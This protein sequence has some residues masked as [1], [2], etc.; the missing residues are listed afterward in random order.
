VSPDQ[1]ITSRRNPRIVAAA[2]LHDA[3]TRKDRGLTLLEGSRLVAE[4]VAAGVRFEVVFV[5]EGTELSGTS[6]GDR[7]YEVVPVTQPV[8]ERLAGT[9]SPTG[10]IAVM[11]I[12]SS[13]ALEPR[14]TVVLCRIADPGTAGT[15]IRSAAAFGYQVAVTPGTVDVWSPK[16]LRAAAGGHFH[17]SVLPVELPLQPTLERAGLEGVALVAAGGSPPEASAAAV[18]ALLVGSEAHGL[19][20]EF[21]DAASHLITIA[22]E[23]GVESLNAAV[24]GAIAMYHYR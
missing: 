17:T 8:L 19:D 24:A 4:A 21:V 23:I 20:D 12:P 10:P 7:S 15:L 3:A 1:V 9:R 6:A 22:T 2:A 5:R 11:A 13:P 14:H 18:P 16:V